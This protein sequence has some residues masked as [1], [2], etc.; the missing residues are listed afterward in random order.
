MCTVTSLA[1]S[2]YGWD[3]HV[4]D[5]PIEWMPDT[6]KMRMAFQITFSVASTFTKLSLLWFCRRI[7]GTGI[8]GPFRVLNYCLIGSM[9]MVFVL[10]LIFIL[11]TI[12]TCMYVVIC[13]PL[14]EGGQGKTN[15]GTSAPSRPRSN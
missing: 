4:W 11:L 1:T 8:K 5:V 2:R 13:Y 12:F 6:L 10:S 7:L 9:M 14:R 15:R 3:R